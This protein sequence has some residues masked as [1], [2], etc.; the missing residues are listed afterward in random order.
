VSAHS[1]AWASSWLMEVVLRISL[2][3][4]PSQPPGSGK[5]VVEAGWRSTSACAFYTAIT[6]HHPLPQQPQ[7]HCLGCHMTGDE[8][9]L[10]RFFSALLRDLVQRPAAAQT[11]VAQVHRS[12]QMPAASPRPSRW[13]ASATA[14]L[15]AAGA[16][17]PNT[18]CISN[19]ISTS[20][21]CTPVTAI[22]L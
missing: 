16:A 18:S 10:G 9:S 5:C 6:T 17:T 19:G 13:A 22:P 21:F 4:A 14:P 15:P 20:C 2:P 3:C 11:H 12:G 1:L 7:L 8:L